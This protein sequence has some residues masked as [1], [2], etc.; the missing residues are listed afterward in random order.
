M[1]AC[2]YKPICRLCRVF[3]QLLVSCLPRH[4]AGAADAQ[5]KRGQELLATYG[6]QF[7]CILEAVFDFGI[8]LKG[9]ACISAV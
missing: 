7:V 6:A 4:S 3:R 9:W 5:R 2:W 8:W 1:E